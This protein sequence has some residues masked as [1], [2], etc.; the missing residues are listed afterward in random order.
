MRKDGTI[1]PGET[2]SRDINFRGESAR[3]VSMRDISQRKDAEAELRRLNRALRTISKCN[4]ALVRSSNQE[5]LLREICKTIVNVGEYHS[6]SIVLVQNDGVSHFLPIFSFAFPPQK[7]SEP[8]G[9][10]STVWDQYSELASHHH[11]RP[12]TCLPQPA[13]GARIEPGI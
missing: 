3:V 4:E 10:T 1:F 13:V 12:P 9:N 7:A 11:T 2:Q 5:E 6:A 8:R